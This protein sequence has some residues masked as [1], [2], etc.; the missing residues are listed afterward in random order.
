LPDRRAKAEKGKDQQGRQR[1]HHKQFFEHWWKLSWDRSDMVAAFR[2]LHGRYIVCSRV[3]KRPIFVF[4]NTNIRPA[5]ALQTFIFDD[6]YS[7]GILQSNVHWNW[8]ITKCAKLLERF[9]YG[10]ESVFET[11]PWPQSPEKKQ[12]SGVAQASR[13]IR[14]IR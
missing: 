11:F 3:T 1:S 14:R 12:I 13:E 8:F 5:D 2:S 7:F 4:V 9:T 10:P 6:D